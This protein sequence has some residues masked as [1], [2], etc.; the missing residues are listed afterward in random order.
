MNKFFDTLWAYRNKVTNKLFGVVKVRHKGNKVGNILLSYITE[1]FTIA[2]HEQRSLL[3]SN[4]QECWVIADIFS[5]KGYDVDVINAT[6]TIFIP[7]KHYAFLIDIKSNIERLRK[8]LPNTTMIMHIVESHHSFHNKAEQNR[9]EQLHK[10]RGVNLK[11]RRVTEPHQ[12]AEKAD[13]LEGL[14]N[15]HTHSTYSHIHKDIYSI[16]ISTTVHF[17]SPTHKNFDAIRKNFLW[18]GGGGAVHK[19]LDIL[20]ELFN[21]MPDYTLHICGPVH[22][23]KDFANLYKKELFK[24]KNIHFHGRISPGSKEFKEITNNTLAVVY[25][26]SSE[27]QAGSVITAM[28]AGIIPIISKESGINSNNFGITLENCTEEEIRKEIEFISTLP[29]Q[30]LKQMSLNTWEYAN[31]H[32]TIETFKKHYEDFV[33]NILHI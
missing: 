8:M 25:P 14:G 10:R 7:K 28:H 6:N 21:K 3:H 17:K 11:R 31:T 12:N 15:E 32:H 22:S 30:T 27:G 5:K 20:L 19:G 23:E 29:T 13:H 4:Y 33:T 1:P 2:L 9:L 26:S 24:T 16:P 18:I